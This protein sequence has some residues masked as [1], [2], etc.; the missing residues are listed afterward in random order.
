MNNVFRPLNPVVNR[1]MFICKV[2]VFLN[3]AKY[4]YNAVFYASL[5]RFNM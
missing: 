5:R 3:R 4:E 2:T 1:N